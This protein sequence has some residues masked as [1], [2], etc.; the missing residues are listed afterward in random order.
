M[1]A[2]RSLGD[3]RINKTGLKPVLFSDGGESFS[4][5]LCGNYKCVLGKPAENRLEGS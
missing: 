1:S 5:N 2:E 3:N 4:V